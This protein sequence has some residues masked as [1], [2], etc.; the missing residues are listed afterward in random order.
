MHARQHSRPISSH[1]ETA[2]VATLACSVVN[3]CLGQRVIV[4]LHE[5]SNLWRAV[6]LVASRR[7]SDTPYED[8]SCIHEA[9]RETQQGQAAI[10]VIPRDEQGITIHGDQEQVLM[11]WG[12][13]KGA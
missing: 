4:A 12:R 2:T 5:D 3:I 10:R 1:V 11:A 7:L 8:I 9:I 6:D 13:D